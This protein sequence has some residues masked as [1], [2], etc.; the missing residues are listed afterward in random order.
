MGAF[1]KTSHTLAIQ[2][3]A[4]RPGNLGGVLWKL[5]SLLLKVREL[6]IVILW[7]SEKLSPQIQV[8]WR[9]NRQENSTF[10]VSF[11]CDQGFPKCK[12][13]KLS[14]VVLVYGFNSARP[15]VPRICTSR[16]H[17]SRIKWK[18]YQSISGWVCRQSCQT[19][20]VQLKHRSDFRFALSLG[21]ASAVW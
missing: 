6:D 19:I 13:M 14:H 4:R 3:G 2:Q 7:F 17:L 15:Q 8:C 21:T 9:I 20:V 18:T 16:Q 12:L 10:V 1:C 5:L 11:R